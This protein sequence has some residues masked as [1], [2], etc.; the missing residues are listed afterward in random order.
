[1]KMLRCIPSLLLFALTASAQIPGQY[2]GQA[3]GQY[4]PGQYPP[5]QYPPGQGP[6]PRIPGQTGPN[7]RPR[8][9]Q[10]QPDNRGK[11][12]DSKSDAKL[13]T[14]TAG[15]LRR[16]ASNQLVIQP[17]DH[18]VVWYRLAPQLTVR[19]DGKDAELKEFA[20]GDYVSVESNADDDGIFTAVSVTWK[21]AGTPEDRDEASKSWDLPRIETAARG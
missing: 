3:P 15:I 4:P 8:T 13:L 18:R 2:P 1:M 7:G 21:K 19:K 10:P 16:A 9:G 6:I 17:D 20:L 12:S 5:G 14:T 11:R